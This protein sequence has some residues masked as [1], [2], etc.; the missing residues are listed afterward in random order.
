MI[1]VHCLLLGAYM[2]SLLAAEGL[3]LFFSCSLLVGGIF[4]GVANN[5]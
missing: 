2:F 5:K 3:F 4:F 1:C